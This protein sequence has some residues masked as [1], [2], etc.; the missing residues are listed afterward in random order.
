MGL[1]ARE[2]LYLFNVHAICA[3]EGRNGRVAEL[4]TTMQDD[5]GSNH[6]EAMTGNDA[7]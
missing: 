5:L 4:P 6:I 7:V 1:V 2:G 3:G